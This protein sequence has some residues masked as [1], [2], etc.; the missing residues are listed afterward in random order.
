MMKLAEEFQHPATPLIHREK[1]S[2]RNPAAKNPVAENP[3][4]LAVRR[5]LG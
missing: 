4:R 5:P 1:P 3:G 2:Y